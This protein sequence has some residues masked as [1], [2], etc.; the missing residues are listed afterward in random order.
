MG[1]EDSRGD[2][3]SRTALTQEK[4]NRTQHINLEKGCPWENRTER[5]K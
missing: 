1:E 3:I 4:L 5:Y 2:Q